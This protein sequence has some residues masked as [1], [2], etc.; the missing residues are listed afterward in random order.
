MMT[1]IRGAGVPSKLN[2]KWLEQAGFKSKNDRPA[3]AVLRFIGFLNGGGEPTEE[4]KSYRGSDGPAVL[5]R[6]LAKSYSDLYQMYPDAH[7]RE[8]GT[9]EDFFS[10]RSN[11]GSAAL[12]AMVLTFQTLCA[13]ASF[14]PQ[15][16]GSP[17]SADAEIPPPAAGGGARQRTL[18]FQTLA[19]NIQ[20]ALPE[21]S[22]AAV[23]EEIFK[24]MKR[25]LLEGIE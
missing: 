24:A 19:I 3:L 5:G 17:R 8:S 12:K 1:H 15:P 16:A 22:N 21:T 13:L 9:L 6:A 23:Y 11:L 10:T 2:V 25:Y 7:R 14:E 18:G 20:L 4:Y